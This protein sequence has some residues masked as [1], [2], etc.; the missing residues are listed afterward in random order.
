[1]TGEPSWTPFTQAQPA[2]C[3]WL[4][5]RKMQYVKDILIK[6]FYLWRVKLCF[7]ADKHFV[8]GNLAIHFQKVQ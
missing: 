5:I 8:K 1:M 4:S 7:Q 3:D 2:K 6:K